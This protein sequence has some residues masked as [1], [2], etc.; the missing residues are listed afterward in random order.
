MS[1]AAVGRWPELR[2]G[3]GTKLFEVADQAILRMKYL[4]FLFLL[5]LSGCATNITVKGTVP[6][7]LVAKAPVKVGVYYSPDFR[8][9][10]HQEVV[11][12]RSTYNIDFGAQNLSFFRTLMSAM[13]QSVVEIQQPPPLAPGTAPQLD[14]IIVPEIVKYGFLT[15]E[16][17]GL[18]FY[19]A[20]INYRIT[21]YNRDGKRVGEWMLVGYGKS[22]A[23]LF[24]G[25][26]ALA[27]ATLLAIRD[28]SARIAIDIPKDPAFVA[29]V[30][31]SANR[32]AENSVVPSK[33]GGGP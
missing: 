13:F 31:E 10:R 24:G 6:T 29:W 12:Q 7:P 20:S 17:S 26:E 28:G 16:I 5:S 1:R 4:C 27:S 32:T 14:G 19:S 15:P 25:D 23:G 9:F 18:N 2:S 22:E 3:P 30:Q 11:D 8:K 21:L 33:E